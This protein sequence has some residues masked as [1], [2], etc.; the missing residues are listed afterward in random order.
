MN[1][2]RSTL[3]HLPF[4]C[5]LAICVAGQT[6]PATAATTSSDVQSAQ[7]AV[8]VAPAEPDVRK[9]NVRLGAFLLSDVKT[10]M[11]LSTEGGAEGTPIDFERTLGGDTS[12]TVFRADASW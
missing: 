7:S 6:S 3:R 8:E 1:N 4:L 12:L 2:T 11:Q 10:T 9:F 5:G